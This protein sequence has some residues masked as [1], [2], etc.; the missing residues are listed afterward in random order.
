MEATL[1]RIELSE[2][3]LVQN[4]AFTVTI[5]MRQSF[6]E[7]RRITPDD[8]VRATQPTQVLIVQSPTGERIESC[9][10]CGMCGARELVVLETSSPCVFGPAL[11]AQDV[12][13][14]VFD[15]CRVTC[16]S[17]RIHIRSTLALVLDIAGLD[18]PLI[19]DPFEVL[20]KLPT[21]RRPTRRSRSRV[22]T[23][24]QLPSQLMPSF[25][26]LAVVPPPPPPPLP[27]IAYGY[28]V[29]VRLFQAIIPDSELVGI[30]SRLL[31]AMKLDPA[32]V[33]YEYERTPKDS[34][35]YFATSVTIYRDQ[36]S[37]EIAH[38]QLIRMY[39]RFYAGRSSWLLFSRSLAY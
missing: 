3:T 1:P 11:V 17:T 2:T 13:R 4:R 25:A 32:F 38:D 36:R 29:S 8:I 31:V 37:A 7:Q 10:R 6:R 12:E 28:Y 15:S 5:L 30:Y 18:A 9:P 22:P 39:H 20:S 35:Q 26:T 16:S 14:F 21:K 19:S 23:E 34:R 27:P 24:A 33:A